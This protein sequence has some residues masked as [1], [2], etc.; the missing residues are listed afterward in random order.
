[1]FIRLLMRCSGDKGAMEEVHE[2]TGACHKRFKTKA[3]AEAFIE[4]WKEAFADVVRRAVKEGLDRGLRPQDMRLGIGGLFRK[5]GE[6]AIE[7]IAEQMKQ[8]SV[9]E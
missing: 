5:G 6:D 9:G 3:Q 8:C 1:M 7:H 2:I 4:D